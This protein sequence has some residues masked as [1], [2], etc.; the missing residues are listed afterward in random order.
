MHYIVIFFLQCRTSS[1]CALVLVVMVQLVG[2]FANNQD[3]MTALL[4]LGTIE[5]AGQDLTTTEFNVL[6][7]VRTSSGFSDGGCSWHDL[8]S[9]MI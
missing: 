6:W 8:P 2:L 4:T 9:S 5:K 3:R 1:F 7:T